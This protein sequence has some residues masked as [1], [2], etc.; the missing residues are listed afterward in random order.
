MSTTTRTGIHEFLASAVIPLQ[1]GGQSVTAQ[2]GETLEVVNPSDGTRLATVSSAS[3]A[4]VEA[5]VRAANAAFPSWSAL[6]VSERSKILRRFSDILLEECSGL[7]ELES[8]DVGKPVAQAAGF[9]IPFGAQAFRY[10]ADIAEQ[11]DPRRP[12]DVPGYDAYETRIPYG[13]CG[14]IVPWNFPFLLLAWGV[15]PAL[16]AGNTVVVKPAELTPLTSL[17]ICRLAEEA[18]IPAGVLNVLPGL[19]E[20]AGAALSQNP[21]IKR[22]AFT[23]SP[24][25]GRIVAQSAAANLVPAKLELGGKGAAVVLKDADV[26]MTAESLVA[27]VTLN[28]G[29]VCCTATRWLVHNDILESFVASASQLM[30]NV[31]VGADSNS[32]SSV[33]PVVSAGQRARIETYLEQ[34][35]ATGAKIVA[36]APIMNGAQHQGFYVTPT[37]LMGEPDNICAREEIFGPVAYIIPFETNEDAVRLVNQSD[38]GLA[39]SVWGSDLDVARS[40]AEQLVAG[41]AWINAHNVFAYGLP[42]GGVNI[43][44]YGGGVNSKETYAD[45]LR[46]ITVARPIA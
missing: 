7:A 33:G 20:V 5:A 45:Y 13:P 40:I 31:P 4:D 18:G 44:G 2:N 39:N 6:P 36:Q 41:N 27:A 10:F 29:Q 46:P 23:G 38:Y 43:S 34:G 21:D 37:L 12:L 22:I 32:A 9:D 24:E 25:V 28:A 19:G 16:A 1:I 26:A 17:Y 30:E 11:T 42:Y 35:V 8:L 14:F 15:A 3:P